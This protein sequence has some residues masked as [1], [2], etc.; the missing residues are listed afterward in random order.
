MTRGGSP[1]NIINKLKLA[2]DRSRGNLYEDYERECIFDEDST[3][4]KFTR[5]WRKCSSLNAR[6]IRYELNRMCPGTSDTCPSNT[7]I[8]ANAFMI[9]SRATSAN[10]NCLP[11]DNAFNFISLIN[12]RLVVE[13]LYAYEFKTQLRNVVYYYCW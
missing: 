13:Q 12:S 2:S 3:A 5:I 7:E 6:D 10:W 8:L 11:G 4:L 1:W 9:I